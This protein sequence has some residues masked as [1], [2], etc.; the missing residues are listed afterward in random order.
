MLH[1]VFAYEHRPVIDTWGNLN[2][3][4]LQSY[5][6]TNSVPG[7]YKQVYTTKAAYCTFSNRCVIRVNVEAE[8][9]RSSGNAC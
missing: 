4:L 3:E 1:F 2:F 9:A 7:K 6:N 5:R 8:F